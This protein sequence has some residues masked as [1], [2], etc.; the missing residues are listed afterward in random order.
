MLAQFTYTYIGEGRK[1]TDLSSALY[2]LIALLVV[3]I[4]LTGLIWRWAPLPN[5]KV[6]LSLGMMIL[7]SQLGLVILAIDDQI[8]YYQS[9]GESTMS[10]GNIQAE[11]FQWPIYVG[12]ACL[13]ICLIM[14]AKS[15]WR[16][17]KERR[18]QE[19]SA[20]AANQAPAYNAGYQQQPVSDN[21]QDAIVPES[22]EQPAGRPTSDLSAI[23]EWMP[24]R[25]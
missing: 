14:V 24:P 20:L 2:P 8:S 17:R 15:R 19:H 1:M 12:L 9:G 10:F 18:L 11:Y 21:S 6:W 22:A 3:S 16:F 13:T 7:V 4:M 25:V 23:L 5:V